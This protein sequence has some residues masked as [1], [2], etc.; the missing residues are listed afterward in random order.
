MN[1]LFDIGHPA[2]VH[3]F[4]HVARQ[5][6][7]DGHTV[8]FTCRHQAITEHL[9]QQEGFAYIAVGGKYRALW[10]KG[11]MVVHLTVWMWFYVIRHR[12]DIGISSGV[13]LS[14]VARFSRMKAIMMND[15]DDAVDPLTVR[16]GHRYAYAVLTP[17]CIQRQ[18]PRAVYYAGT[19]E[20]AYLHPNRFKPDNEVLN[21]VGLQQSETYFVVRF[22]AF[23]GHHDLHERGLSS[24]QK[25]QLVQLLSQHGRVLITVEKSLPKNLEPY[26]ALV[27]PEQMHSLL[28]NATLYI[29]DSQTMTSEAALLGVPAVKCNTFAGRLSVPNM[30]EQYG[31]CYSF[32]PD[33]FDE[34]CRLIEELISKPDIRNIW[35]ERRNRFLSEHIDVTA[36]FTSYLEQLSPKKQSFADFTIGQYH[37]LLDA[38]DTSGIDYTLRH[39]VD[40]HP[41]RAV[42]M[43]QIEHDRGIHATYYFRHRRN[44]WE[45]AAIRKVVGLGHDVGY[46]YES[47]ATC[48]GDIDA[49]YKDFC[50]HLKELRQITPVHTICMHGSP[51]SPYDSR[52]IWTHYDYHALGVDN[53]PYLGT[54]FSQTLYLTD[55]GRQWDGWHYSRRDLIPDHQQR[56]EHE[57]LRFHNTHDI[58]RALSDRS[59]PIHHYHL[60]INIH[61]QR[62]MPF[63][64][65]WCL[66]WIGQKMKNPIKRL[67][68]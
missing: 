46:H 31:L 5:L 19:H 23:H 24:Q 22:V 13:V 33:R 58:I 17:D 50:Q 47:L 11:L 28:A 53:E 39:D 56:W 59:H 57:G 3:L 27:A 61:P 67:Y 35:A 30:L 20:L 18:T 26:R 32:T 52:K 38:L 48:H 65:K 55:T 45:E 60:L 29:G 51:R 49:A 7:Q 64:M 40:A 41:E 6:Q 62:W 8:Y 14:Q 9:L 1:I 25:E 63:G 2:H 15:D 66:E 36:Y 44:G 42:G 43:A 12:I 16:W 34:M 37:K 21:T 54:D 68:K 10:R 4:K